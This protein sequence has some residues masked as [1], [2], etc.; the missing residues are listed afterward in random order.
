MSRVVIIPDDDGLDETSKAELFARFQSQ[1]CRWCGGLHQQECPRIR[2]VVYNPS[3]SREVREIEFWSDGEW[4]KS[5]VL[6]PEDVI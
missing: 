6:F 4:D 3:D 2:R 1:S 5:S